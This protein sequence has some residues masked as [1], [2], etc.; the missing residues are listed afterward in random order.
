MGGGTMRLKQV[1]LRKPVENQV[2]PKKVKQKFKSKH[3]LGKITFK[4]L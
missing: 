4:E 2:W 3:Y 1:T